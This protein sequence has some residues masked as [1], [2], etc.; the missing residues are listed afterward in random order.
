LT[1]GLVE[2]SYDDARAMIGTRAEVEFADHEVTWALI[3]YFCAMVRDNNASYWD[4]DFARAEWGGVVS[5]PAML[6]TWVM[7]PDWQPEAPEPKTLL[8][9]R[10]PLPDPTVI[11]VETDTELFRPIRAGD[12]LNVEETLVDVS[13]RKST[14]LG[15]GHFVTTEALF[16]AGDGTPVA[17]YRH[18]LF[19]YTPRAPASQ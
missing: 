7:A 10:V 12:W 13:P 17:R 11:S 6:L 19:R 14:E 8:L 1:F 15:D 3:K 9:A 18:V 16:R 5:P 2:G 4:P